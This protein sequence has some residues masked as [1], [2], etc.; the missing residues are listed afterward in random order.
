MRIGSIFQWISLEFEQSICR[1]FQGTLFCEGIHELYVM[2]TVKPSFVQLFCYRMTIFHDL[3]T[4][5]SCLYAMIFNI[6]RCL[7]LIGHTVKYVT[8]NCNQ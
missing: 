7:L 8:L 1:N 6:L 3:H 4:V 5:I 2:L